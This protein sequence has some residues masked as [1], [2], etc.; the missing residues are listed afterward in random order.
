MHKVL[1]NSTLPKPPTPSVEITS[2][3][4]KGIADAKLVSV[5][6]SS[7]ISCDTGGVDGVLLPDLLK[8]LVRIYKTLIIDYI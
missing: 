2:R 8:E 7:I 6:L 5:S 1:T 4:L 3:L